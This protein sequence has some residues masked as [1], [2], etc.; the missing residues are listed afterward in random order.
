MANEKIKKLNLLE[1]DPVTIK[2]KDIIKQYENTVTYNISEL[3]KGMWEHNSIIT[4]K[5]FKAAIGNAC[6]M[7]K[8]YSQHDSQEL[9][10]M[11]ID[12]IHE[13]TKAGVKVVYKNIPECVENYIQLSNECTSIINDPDSDIDDKEKYLN[14]LKEYKKEHST[15]VI[16]SNA[17]LYWERY[18]QNSHSII[19]DLFTGLFLSKITCTECQNVSSVFE[20]FTSLSIQTKEFGET[21]LVESMDGFTAE[22]TLTNNNKYFCEICNKKVDAKK[23]IYI[24]EPPNILI[25]HLKRFKHDKYFPTKTRS[26]VNF[27]IN[28]FDI[29]KYISE[30]HDIDNTVY[31]LSAIS[32]HQGQYGSGHYI[33]YCKNSI[34]DKWYEFNDDDVIHIPNDQ[35][36]KE[37]VTTNAY[38]LFYVRK[39]N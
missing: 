37:I 22:E 6:P 20:P 28:G 16:I 31:D 4:P 32:E 1:N 14:Y 23:K 26:K 9:L 5:S 34:N 38:V 2:K 17:Y 35:L 19:T 33:A 12:R 3:I 24:W 8:G 27:P 25:V 30:L 29:Q 21:T 15:E 39:F 36:E 11:I 10:N 7:F 13:E 18:I